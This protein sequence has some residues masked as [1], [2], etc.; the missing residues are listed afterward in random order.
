MN[1]HEQ[2]LTILINYSNDLANL[3]K[4]NGKLPAQAAI[5]AIEKLLI[6]ARVETEKAYGGCHLCYGKGYHT[7]RVGTS[8][9]YGNVTHDTIGYCTCGRGKQLS[10]LTASKSE[11]KEV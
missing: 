2:I 1:E 9:R 10:A 3:Q 6:D 4:R 5:A 8:S 11:E 7:K